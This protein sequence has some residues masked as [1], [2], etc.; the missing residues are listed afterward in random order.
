MDENKCSGDCIKCHVNQRIYCAAQHGHA[1]MAA[2]PPLFERLDRIEKA[3]SRF[4]ASIINPLEDDAQNDSGAEN[5]E[6]KKS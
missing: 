3:L 4:D 6:S 5:R 2:L 1:I